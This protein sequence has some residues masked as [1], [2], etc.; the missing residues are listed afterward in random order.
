VD[1]LQDSLYTLSVLFGVLRLPKVT[2]LY[3]CGTT[4]PVRTGSDDVWMSTVEARR[5]TR[6]FAGIGLSTEY[7]T[8]Q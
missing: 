8:T 4:K 1:E 2:L 6:N 5:F 7:E 3:G